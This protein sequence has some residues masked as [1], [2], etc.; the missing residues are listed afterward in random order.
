MANSKY[1][2][3]FT[4]VIYEEFTRMYQLLEL[5]SIYQSPVHYSPKVEF[6]IGEYTKPK[7][8]HRHL[9]F[10]TANSYT[11]NTF[12]EKL[13]KILNNDLT[14]ISIHIGDTLVKNP[15]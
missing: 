14:G 8:P 9:L 6:Y 7:K 15:N 5:G 3:Y 10:K 4:V 13:V 2:Y 11:E 12:I 1:S